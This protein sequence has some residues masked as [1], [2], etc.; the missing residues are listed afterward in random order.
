MAKLHVILASKPAISLLRIYSKVI[1]AK[2]KKKKPFFVALFNNRKGME[3]AY[4]LKQTLF[5]LVQSLLPFLFSPLFATSPSPP[6]LDLNKLQKFQK[7]S[8]RTALT[9]AA[10]RLIPRIP[11][12][13]HEE[14]EPPLT[15][16]ATSSPTTQVKWHGHPTGG[17]CAP[18]FSH[19]EIPGLK[20][21]GELSDSQVLP[22]AH[23]L[24][25]ACN[26]YLNHFNYDF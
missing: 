14:P 2:K 21:L 26:L 9:V 16:L 24:N 1:L 17:V 7:Y 25:K 18:T 5:S 8:L 4:K 10:R 11:N 3:T 22:S 15:V 12:L 23:Q 20:Q 6:P 13:R 19:C